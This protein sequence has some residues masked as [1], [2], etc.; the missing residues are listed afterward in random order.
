MIT[1]AVAVSIHA[2]SPVS[3]FACAMSAVIRSRPHRR[4]GAMIDLARADPDGSHQRNDEDLAV[5]DL[6]RAGALAERL[7]GGLDEVLAHGDL[8][9]DLVGEPHLHGRA[10]VGL[11]ALE[12]A[13]VALDAAD[14]DTADLG[15]VERLQDVVDLLRPDDADHEL[16]SA[17]P[18]SNVDARRERHGGLPRGAMRPPEGRRETYLSSAEGAITGA[19]LRGRAPVAQLDR[20]SVYGT[21]GQRFESSRARSGSRSVERLLR[22]RGRPRGARVRPRWTQYGGAPHRCRPRHRLRA[23]HGARVRRRGG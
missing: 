18:L 14:R 1:S 21:E 17:A 7:D 5:A 13:A 2:V 4:D 16:H 6:A 9:A 8:A 22:F 15:A 20:A 23:R 3:T 10:T 19:T 12:L 11:D